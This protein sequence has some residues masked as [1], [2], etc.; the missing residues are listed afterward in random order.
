MHLK[1]SFNIIIFSFID[2][3][4]VKTVKKNVPKYLALKGGTMLF[5]AFRVVYSVKEL[6]SHAKHGQ[7]LKKRFGCITEY[8]CAKNLPSGFVQVSKGFFQSW[9]LLT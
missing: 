6:D 5:R 8:F 4:F 3:L 1:T 9:L 2:V 7:S